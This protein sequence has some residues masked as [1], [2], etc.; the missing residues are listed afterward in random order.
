M[1]LL[2]F[3]G[4]PSPPLNLRR[5]VVGLLG[6]EREYRMYWSA[7]NDTG[8]LAVNYTVQLCV[9][10]S[11]ANHSNNQCK[12]SSGS[13]CQVSNISDTNINFSCTLNIMVDFQFN[14]CDEFCNYTVCVV[15]TN[16][17]G[18]TASCIPAPYVDPSL[19]E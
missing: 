16:D 17:V 15:A 5:S 8:G 2:T 1:H 10:D 4:P 6:L 9:N 11:L 7:S 14:T 12:F 3:L 13:G 18:S 19:G